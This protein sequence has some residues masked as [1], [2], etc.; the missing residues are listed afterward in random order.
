MI[1]IIKK[2][3][4]F[5]IGGLILLTSLLSAC[6]KDT[7]TVASNDIGTACEGNIYLEKFHCSIEEVQQAA[8]AG[9]ADAQYA[10]GYMYYY[11]VGTVRDQQTATLWIQRSA[12]AGQP[13]ALKAQKMMAKTPA[14]AS[15]QAASNTTPSVNAPHEDSVAVASASQPS[16]AA[17]TTH[18]VTAGGSS[19]DQT[20]MSRRS[21]H[22][23]LQLMGSYDKR[24][25]QR[26]I[27]Q[28]NIEGEAIFYQSQYHNKPWYTLVYG[29]YNS[30]ASAQQAINTLSPSLQK[31]KPWIKPIARVQKEL[32]T[33][34]VL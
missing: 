16:K 5:A 25:I 28:E 14:T 31:L 22:Y 4:H 33:H 8:L 9:N 13:L 1:S 3:R 18:S 34:Q 12:S 17:S 30:Y 26:F 19:V 24:I 11:G 20:L 21:S 6:A 2:Q 23:T 32:Q 7:A 15:S 27:A 29:D 10:L